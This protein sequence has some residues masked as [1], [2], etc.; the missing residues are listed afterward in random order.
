MKTLPSSC[1]VLVCV[2]CVL[3]LLL[4]VSCSNSHSEVTL[5]EARINQLVDVAWKETVSAG[6]QVQRVI[7]W[8]DIF[9][10][11]Y[12]RVQSC[13]VIRASEHQ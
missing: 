11:A 6:T 13:H 7:K 12:S 4:L 3:H 5:D 10:D 1:I 2:T 8:R 9:H